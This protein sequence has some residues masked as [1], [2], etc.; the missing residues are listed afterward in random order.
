[1]SFTIKFKDLL[2]LAIGTPDPGVVVNFNALHILLHSIMEHLNLEEQTQVLPGSEKDYL[3]CSPFQV[4]SGKKPGKKSEESEEDI[5]Y[6][7][8]FD[9]IINTFGQ[10]LSVVESQMAFLEALPSTEQLLESSL[11]FKKPAQDMWQMLKLQKKVEGNEEGMT[12]A[13]QTLQELLTTIYTLQSDTDY[14]RMEMEQLKEKVDKISLDEVNKHSEELKDQQD[15]L[16]HLQLDME[17]IK[18]KLCS[19]PD[20]SDIMQWTTLH[21]AMYSQADTKETSEKAEAKT[22]E[23]TPQVTS[24]EASK[25]LKTPKTP[26]TRIPP[27]KTAQPR[28]DTMPSPF[29]KALVAMG[30]T[31]DAETLASVGIAIDPG[32]LT[33]MGITTDPHI[34]ATMG[35]TPVPGAGLGTAGEPG[36]T[37]ASTTGRSFIGPSSTGHSSSAGPPSSTGPSSTAGLSLGISPDLSWNASSFLAALGIIP[38]E[39]TLDEL[40]IDTNAD[41]LTALGST[42]DPAT[43][44]ALAVLTGKGLPTQLHSPVP[45]PTLLEVLGTTTESKTRVVPE[46]STSLDTTAGKGTP[47]AVSSPHSPVKSSSQ[48]SEGIVSSTKSLKQ[49][50]TGQPLS[51]EGKR[52]TTKRS[53]GR[54]I[55]LPTEYD[56]LKEQ[57]A[58][59]E[60]KVQQQANCLANLQFLNSLGLTP[61]LDSEM[62]RLRDKINT[63]Q[64]SGQKNKA[65]EQHLEKVQEHC[66]LLEK[67]TETLQDKMEDIKGL[68]IVVKQLEMRK[69]DKTRMEEQMKEKADKSAL[70]FK[71]SRADLEFATVQLHDMMHD[72]LQKISVHEQDWQKVLEKLFLDVDSKLGHMDLDP[73]KKQMEHIW[74]FVKKHL[75]EG[76]RFDADSAAGFKKQ[77]FERVKCISCDRPVEMMTSPQL[78]SIQKEN[79]YPYARPVSA[80]SYEY[81]QRLKLSGVT[82]RIIPCNNYPMKGYKPIF[83]LKKQGATIMQWRRL[84]SKIREQQR[85]QHPQPTQEQANMPRDGQSYWDNSSSLRR[86]MKI[87][88]LTTLYPYGDPSVFPEN[89][90][91]NILGVDGVMYKGRMASRGAPHSVI[92]EKDLAG[93]KSPRAPSSRSACEHIRS[94]V[95]GAMYP[96]SRPRTSMTA[97][98]LQ[99]FTSQ[100]MLTSGTLQHSPSSAANMSSTKNRPVCRP[101]TSS[102]PFAAKPS[103]AS[104]PINGFNPISPEEGTSM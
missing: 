95:S 6:H 44:V 25:T 16:K 15:Q 80:N 4:T 5:L 2:N 37:A 14:F 73:V 83:G 22:S 77:L 101:A 96:A 67:V 75:S 94:S 30:I 84:C 55:N 24:E 103:S 78:I 41:S 56:S 51:A 82:N 76:P 97:H 40:G 49:L 47:V 58:K 48:V 79:L 102:G 86:I 81:L 70:A 36:T 104:L 12:K 34:L 92:T 74:K 43:L 72:M 10:R 39:T 88:N 45:V 29:D 21:D 71:A 33:A 50:L 64:E 27:V 17:D 18:N 66:N 26:S 32:I 42:V 11:P 69:V 89:S 38:N 59:L 52:L 19:F 98:V 35:I 63:L 46:N 60:D 85:T 28:S 57:F 91:V 68:K 13:M 65:Y 23:V 93:L 100:P 31:T 8:P 7:T 99:Q 61:Q 54:L 9:R 20:G 90:E 3:P 62:S 87:P 53:M 1:M